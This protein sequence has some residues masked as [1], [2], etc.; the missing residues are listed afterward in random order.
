VPAALKDY[1]AVKTH[2]TTDSE[3][4]KCVDYC[5]KRD[6][7]L[8][9]ARLQKK[10]KVFNGGRKKGQYLIARVST[11]RGLDKY[12]KMIK[13]KMP[14]CCNSLRQNPRVNAWC[15]YHSSEKRRR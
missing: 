5:F 13:K 15:A 1:V 9:N 12:A 3:V 11:C 8:R 10:I 14:E 2:S 7:H 6:W 4:S